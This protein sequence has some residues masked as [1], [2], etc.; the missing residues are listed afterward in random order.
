[1][2]QMTWEAGPQSPIALLAV[3]SS[4]G[5]FQHIVNTL[6]PDGCDQPLRHYVRVQ[7][8]HH[9]VDVEYKCTRENG[10]RLALDEGYMEVSPYGRP[11]W[12]GDANH[13]LYLFTKSLNAKD[14]PGGVLAFWIWARQSLGL[15]WRSGE[16]A[17]PAIQFALDGKMYWLVAVQASSY[18]VHCAQSQLNCDAHKVLHSVCLDKALPE[19]DAWTPNRKWLKFRNLWRNRAGQQLAPTSFADVLLCMGIDPSRLGDSWRR[20]LTGCAT[21]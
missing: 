4:L 17:W 18:S 3:D 6:I 13:K 9:G 15:R 16:E 5:R 11:S 21:P 19:G 20:A 7:H 2:N 14:N 12:H 8:V 1:M 10:Y